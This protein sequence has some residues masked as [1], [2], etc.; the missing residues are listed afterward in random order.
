MQ[1][2]MPILGRRAPPTNVKPYASENTSVGWVFAD[3]D[4]Q[5]N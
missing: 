4:K 2:G 3:R 1:T 5:V